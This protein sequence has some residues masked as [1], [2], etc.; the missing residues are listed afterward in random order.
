MFVVFL[1]VRY[2]YEYTLYLWLCSKS[3]K[4]VNENKKKNWFYLCLLMHIIQ[5]G[6]K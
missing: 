4:I 5:Q 6:E 2:G 1:Q 3:L